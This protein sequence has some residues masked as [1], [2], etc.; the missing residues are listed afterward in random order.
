MQLST[1]RRIAF[2]ASADAVW[3]AMCDV[4]SYQSWWPWLRTFDANALEVGQI[5]RCEIVAPL[6]YTVAFTLKF[7]VV[8]APFHIEASLRGDI[9]GGAWIDV[10][11]RGEQSDVWIRS[12]IFP[13][14]RFLRALTRFAYPI[15]RSGHDAIIT[16][17]A[18][19]FERRALATAGA[20]DTT[21]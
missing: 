12:E 9:L 19:Q 1:D 18:R 20:A 4:G 14:S 11:E 21:R 5:W 16:S 8:A 13:A 2:D 6:R 7:D 17:G 10:E 3:S 15:A